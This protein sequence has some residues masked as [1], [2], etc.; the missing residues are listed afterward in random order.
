MRILRI[1][2]IAAAVLALPILGLIAYAGWESAHM[3][4]PSLENES[5]FLRAYDPKVVLMPFIYEMQGY[6]EPGGIGGGA[7]TKFVTHFAHFGEYFTIR[8]DRKDSLMAAVNDNVTQRLRMSGARI[9]NQSGTSSSG[10][11]IDYE[12]GKTIGS[13]AI[14]PLCPGAVHRNL[15]LPSG[16]EDV[17][18]NLSVSEQWYPRG[19]PTGVHGSL[20]ESDR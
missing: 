16:L 7:G 10:F 18:L 14:Q 1:V 3:V 11:H 8:A 20:S 6:T 4:Y 13:V 15:P 12:S 17:S 19:I 2:G 5:A 9:L